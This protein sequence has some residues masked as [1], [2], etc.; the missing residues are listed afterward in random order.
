MEIQRFHERLEVAANSQIAL[1]SAAQLDE[2]AEHSSV[3]REHFEVSCD[4]ASE[5]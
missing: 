4:T 5:G 3:I 2:N 1:R